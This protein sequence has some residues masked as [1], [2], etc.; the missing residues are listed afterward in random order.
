[1]VGF[2]GETEEQFQE[3]LDFVVEYKLDNVGTFIYSNE[4]MAWSSKLPDHVPEATKAE[5]YDRLMKA[6]LDVIRER[7]HRRVRSKERLQVVIEGFHEEYDDLIVGRYYGQCPDIDGQIIIND[8]D[9]IG[10]LPIPG[11]RY[12]VELTGFDDYDLIGKIV[13]RK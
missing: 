5:R 11:E 3:L 6:Q 7:N 1:M 8:V 4:E 2:P 12:W 9:E 10:K 13:R